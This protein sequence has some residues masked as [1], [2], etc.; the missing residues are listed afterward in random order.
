MMNK[1]SILAICAALAV[2]AAI[3]PA[4][5]QTANDK[6]GVNS[7]AAA[8]PTT[9]EFVQQVAM[10][11][12]FEIQSSQ[13]AEQKVSDAQTKAFARDMVADHTKTSQQLKG[14]MQ[15]GTVKQT[16][17]KSLDAAHQQ[18][19]DQ[20]KKLS[21]QDFA[22][23]YHAQQVAAHQDA[24]ELFQRYAKGGDNAALKD[25]AAKTL[26]AL[27]HHLDMAQSLDKRS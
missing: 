3:A 4:L 14:M 25:W 23:Q 12:M 27:Q 21:G 10:S 9:A 2:P 15:N 22:R 19:L 11:D 17:P 16:P 20:L 8:S 13:L 18:K 1:I 5:A 26:P 24:V 7:A 6:T